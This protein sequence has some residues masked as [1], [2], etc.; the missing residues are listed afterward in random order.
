[1]AHW[2]HS[3]VFAEVKVDE[4]LGIVRVT[5]VV[6]AVAGGRILNPKTARSQLL[7]GVVWGIGAALEEDSVVDHRMGRVITHNLADYHVPVNADVHNIDIIFVE[8][9]DKF[10][11]PLG[12]KGLGEIGIVG[13]AP[14]I[15]N[16]VFHATGV[17]IRELPIT[18]DK[19]ALIG[20][21]YDV[22]VPAA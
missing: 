16:A 21:Q 22:I 5:R 10:V 1:Y 17:R 2:A 4:D 20:S 7:G 15:A 18:L 11:N 3:A 6:S 9:N 8:E 13:V 19:V 14:A 12:A